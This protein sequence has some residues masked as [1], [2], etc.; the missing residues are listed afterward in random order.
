M[1]MEQMNMEQTTTEFNPQE[2]LMKIKTIRESDDPLMKCEKLMEVLFGA[3]DRND[4][5][6]VFAEHVLRLEG[7]KHIDEWYDEVMEDH[8][9]WL[10]Q[11]NLKNAIEV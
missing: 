4:I 9:V 5:I 10:H 6:E 2:E 8:K 11:L 3:L 1:N 7:E